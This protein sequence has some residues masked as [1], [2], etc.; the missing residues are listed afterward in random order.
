MLR[1]LQVD[2]RGLAVRVGDPV[3]TG[4]RVL[5]SGSRF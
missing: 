2:E 5:V 1:K 4:V 3:R